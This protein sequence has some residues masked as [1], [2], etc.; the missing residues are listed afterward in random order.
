ME[1]GEAKDPP[2]EHSLVRTVVEYLQKL[3]PSQV[4]HKLRVNAKFLREPK[5]VHIVLAILPELLAQS[6]QHPIQPSEHIWRIVNLRLE[7]CNPSHQ[8]RCCLLVKQLANHRRSGFRKV[9]CDRRD[10]KSELAGRVLIV[11]DEL[12]KS[13]LIRRHR[14]ASRT[15]RGDDLEI[16]ADGCAGGDHAKLPRACLAN[17]DLRL[18]DGPTLLVHG[19]GM[20]NHARDLELLCRLDIEG[21]VEPHGEVTFGVLCEE[22]EEGLFED[23]GSK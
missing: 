6:D 13:T 15:R 23:G 2:V 1:G 22:A 12:D 21:G 5:A 20:A 4:K 19:D 17:A 11:C 7:Y 16:Y 3:T 18:A 9:A 10:P 14:G 8:N